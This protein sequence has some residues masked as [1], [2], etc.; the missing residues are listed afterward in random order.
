MQAVL[1]H[2]IEVYR[3]MRFLEE[4]NLA[5]AKLR[6]DGK[7]WLELELERSEWEGTLAD[8]L[9]STEKRLRNQSKKRSREHRR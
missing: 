7:A 4:V 8:G 6:Q 2:A 9:E 5:Y 3:R 1:D